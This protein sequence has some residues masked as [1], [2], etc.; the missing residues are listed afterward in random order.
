MELVYGKAL[1]KRNTPLTAPRASHVVSVSRVS[2]ELSARWWVGAGGATLGSF[3]AV[4]PNLQP[5][6]EPLRGGAPG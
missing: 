1:L 5:E 4:R 3:E 6:S 2:G